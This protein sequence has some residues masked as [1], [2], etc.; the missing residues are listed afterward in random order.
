MNEVDTANASKGEQHRVLSDVMRRRRSV[1]QFERGRKVSRDTLL[2]V[3]ESARWA[4]TGANS[5]C[6]RTPWRYSSLW[7]TLAGR[8]LS[9]STMKMPKEWMN[10]L[11]ITKI[12]TIVH[13]VP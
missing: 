4:P 11:Q 10:T 12:F 13:W 8:S 2:S 5:Q 6:C 9:R 1:R 3:A 7:V